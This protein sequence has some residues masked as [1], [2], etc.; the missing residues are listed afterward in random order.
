MAW[1]FHRKY[2]GP[3]RRG[4]RFQVRFLERRGKRADTDETEPKSALRALLER[5]VKWVD[6]ASYFGPDRRGAFSHYILERRRLE[7]AGNPPP[8]HAALRQLRMRVLDAETPEGRSA[9]KDRLA[10]T[11]L[12]AH[13]HGADAIGDHLSRLADGL[14]DA[15]E[16]FLSELPSE[17]IAAEAML[18]DAS[19]FAP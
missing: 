2:V 14:E 16:D 6:V 7:A 10:A 5:G 8:L 4:G 1:L 12:L 15:S 18:N 11:A 19:E 17:L 13:A 3:D 9:L